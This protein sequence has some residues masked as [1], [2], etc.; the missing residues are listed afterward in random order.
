MTLQRLLLA[1]ACVVIAGGV[2]GIMTAGFQERAAR[3]GAQRWEAPPA[4]TEITGVYDRLSA[5]GQFG[6]ALLTAGPEETVGVQQDAAPTLI[7]TATLDGVL[8]A[9]F[10]TSG[11]EILSV[12]ADDALPGGWKLKNTSLEEVTLAKDD[13]LIVLKVFPKE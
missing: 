12:G 1:A 8:Q 11:G 4:R 7:A 3:D 6:Q 9:T 10:L 2:I 5:T 13:T